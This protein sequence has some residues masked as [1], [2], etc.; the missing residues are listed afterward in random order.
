MT[1]VTAA[2]RSLNDDLSFDVA[3]AHAQS[4]IGRA[5]RFE[6]DR[7]DGATWQR[8]ALLV[9][10]FGPH[11][12]LC[13]RGTRLVLSCTFSF[14]SL[15]RR[16]GAH[17]VYK[18]LAGLGLATLT[19][20]VPGVAGVIDAQVA[21]QLGSIEAEML[22]EGDR[23]ALV[24]LP[25][26]GMP[27]DDV[28]ELCEQMRRSDSFVSSGGKAWGGIY[29]EAASALTELQARAW[30]TY[31]TSNALYPKDFASLRKMEA[32]LRQ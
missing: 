22:G 26:T 6:F 14:V 7:P 19:K 16:A 5:A 25:R 15:Y 32:E 12:W 4:C 3:L 2:L 30:A 17:G 24:A 27:T 11:V 8:L 18:R 31:N 28:A 23:D 1:D 20:F 29:H 9:L 21:T 10:L 13:V